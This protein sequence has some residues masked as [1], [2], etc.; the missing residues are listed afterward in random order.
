MEAIALLLRERATI[1]K[2]VIA[3]MVFGLVIA[4]LRP[5]SYTTTFSFIPQANEDAARGGLASLAG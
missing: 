5:A 3:G 2:F 1:L 4:L